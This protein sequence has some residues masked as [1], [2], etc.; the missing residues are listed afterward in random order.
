M[1]SSC[2]SIN[3]GRRQQSRFLN[4]KKIQ[5]NYF[6]HASRKYDWRAISNGFGRKFNNVEAT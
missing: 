3:E 4:L 5:T 2:T 6:S 1:E